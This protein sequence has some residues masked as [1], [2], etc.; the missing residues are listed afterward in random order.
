MKKINLEGFQ[1]IPNTDGKYLIHPDGRVYS[2]Y[3]NKILTHTIQKDGKRTVSMRY[4]GSKGTAVAVSRLLAE[5]FL[6]NP[7]NLKYVI[8]KDGDPRNVTLSNVKWSNRKPKHNGGKY[9]EGYEYL[10]KIYRDGRVYSIKRGKF[11]KPRLIPNGTL[12]VALTDSNG[13][14]KHYLLA[15]LLYSHFIRPLRPGERVTYKDKIGTNISLSN[16]RAEWL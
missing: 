2:R 13:I 8:L 10:Y 3:S 7:N 16:L 14:T 1:E 15:T 6:P 9:I 5:T 11:I 4:A 12:Y